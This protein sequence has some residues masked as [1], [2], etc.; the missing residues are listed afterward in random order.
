MKRAVIVLTSL[1]VLVG[2]AYFSGSKWLIRHETA[3]FFDQS[4]DRPV[5]VDIA[6]RRD[7]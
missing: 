1:L 3:T 2:A 7:K 4:R 5:Q 6:V